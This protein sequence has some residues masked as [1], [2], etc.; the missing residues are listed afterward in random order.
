MGHTKKADTP[1]RG[2]PRKTKGER[3][4]ITLRLGDEDEIIINLVKLTA[5]A[6]E[7]NPSIDRTDVARDCLLEGT[8]RR[9]GRLS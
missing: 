6:Q 3:S 4:D 8:R 2:R 1:K 9:L 5:M 7:T